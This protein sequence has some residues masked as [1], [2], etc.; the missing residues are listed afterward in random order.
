M[1]DEIVTRAGAR[2]Q[3]LVRYFTREPCRRNHISERYVASGKCCQCERETFRAYYLKNRDKNIKKVLDW[4]AANAERYKEAIKNLTASGYWRDWRG[5]NLEKA[6]EYERRWYAEK[7]N[8]AASL[9]NRRARK[10]AS[11]G[12][13]TA[14]DLRAILS[15]QNTRCAYCRADLRKVRRHLDHVMP[16]ALGGTNNKENLQYLC[17]DC[18]LLKGAK[19][20][21][22]YARER[23]LLL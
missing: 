16:L 22:E 6:R 14:A 23:G 5:K 2:A 21:H 7:Q 19:D 17:R 4:R 12:S 15:A 20:P 11:P 3:G 18:N 10:R 8:K 9:H 1:A 13:H